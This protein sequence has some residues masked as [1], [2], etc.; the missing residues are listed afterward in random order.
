MNKL[1]Y[2]ADKLYDTHSLSVDEYEYLL[3]NR[4]E[5]IT[6]YLRQKA[7]AVRFSVYGKKVFIRGLI[8]IS[9]ICKNNCL[10]CGIRGGNSSCERYRLSFQD[11]LSCCDEGYRLGFR[12]FVLQGGED[13]FFTDSFLVDLIK[14]I[15]EKYPD[16]A[17]TLSLGERSYE[18]YQLLYNAGADRY[19]L[20]HEAVN[21]ELYNKLH[22]EN[23]SLKNRLSCLDNL[24]KIGFQTGCGFMVGAPYQTLRH[25][26][27]DLKYI[28]E[29]SPQMCGIGP[30]IPHKATVF[31]DFS[32]GGVELICYLLSIIR[33][34]KPNILLPA[35]TALGTITENGR[36][37]GI[38]SG[39]NVVMPNLSPYTV[40]KKYD[41]YDNKLSTGVESAN[42]LKELNNRLNKIG[43]EIEISRGDIKEK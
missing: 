7:D 11:V 1:Y 4:N 19:L 20:R 33:L 28:E 21:E 26:A 36:E 25:I 10:Y 17:L 29:F 40:R 43:Y 5:Q 12:T 31:K 16:C 39:A 35:T 18:S 27:E 15:K 41:L 14:A 24:K 23:M 9:N 13:S 2:L 37:Q 42:H 3:I 32:A 30:F 34:I 38:L 8:E 22:P 6:E